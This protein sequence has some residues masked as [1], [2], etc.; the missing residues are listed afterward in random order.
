MPESPSR[1]PLS[2]SAEGAKRRH[3]APW[4]VV[5][6]WDS[7]LRMRFNPE[8]LPVN[9]LISEIEGKRIA[10]P[11]FQREFIWRPPAIAD[12]IRTVARRWPA[13]TFLLL[14]VEGKPEFAYKGIEGAP[15]PVQPKTLI[16]DGQQRTT[17]IFQAITETSPETYYVEMGQ[18]QE[19]GE[20]DDEDLK[21]ARNGGFAR[22]FPTLKAMVDRRVVK[23]A[24]LASDREFNKWLRLIEDEEDQDEML[25]IREELLPGL[26]EYDMPVVR[27]PATAPLAAIA[28]IFETIN[29]TGVRL[30]TFDLMVARLYPYDFR[31]RDEWDKARDKN[32]EFEDFGV[33]DGIEILKVIALREHLR[34][35]ESGIKV[36]INGVRESDVLGLGPELVKAD[37]SIA[38]D[39]YVK[40]LRFVKRNCGVIRRGLMPSMTMVLPLAEIQAG[41]RARRKGLQADLKRW[42]WA[43]AFT[44]TYA[45][46]ANTRA[47]KDARELRAWNADD[48]T[49]PEV[50]RTF[51]VDSELLKDGRR[52]NEMLLRGLLCRSVTRD[53]RDWIEDKRF[54]E[55]GS[56]KLEFHHV[57]PDEYLEKHYEGDPDPVVNFVLLTEET[58]K[59]LRNT[60]PADVLE[61]PDISSEAI[62]SARINTDLLKKGSK[63]P[64]QYIKAFLDAR[65]ESLEDVIYDTVG[66]KKPSS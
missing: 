39:A 38:V 49:V 56:H 24:T 22:E 31:L 19:D 8:N 48:S 43:T 47:V 29:R 53:A 40:A 41:D 51:Y 30:A 58:N 26:R 63:K 50:L 14:E 20:F 45:Q 6:H 21:Y 62:E 12:F 33:D 46:G 2:P 44:Q 23:V 1:C 60:I 25:R 61:R 15:K 32:D 10:L 36:T 16:L 18:V 42:F 27:L 37:W 11:E 13:G 64:P 34:Q 55:L 35:R 57:F 66:V 17:A 52:R 5:P 65:A 59:K 4:F 3:V 7:F 54:Q 28:K 9:E